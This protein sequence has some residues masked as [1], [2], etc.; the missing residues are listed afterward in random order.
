MEVKQG[1]YY[2]CLLYAKRKWACLKGQNDRLLSGE[3]RSQ[4]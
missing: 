3:V 4:V 1:Q 2:L